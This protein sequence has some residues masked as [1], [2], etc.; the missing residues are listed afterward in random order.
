MTHSLFGSKLLA[1]LLGVS[2]S[3]A[4]LYA[5]NA[6]AAT[7]C[8]TIGPYDIL[9]HQ[10]ELYF[11]L[12]L[13][14]PLYEL[15]LEIII[16]LGYLLYIYMFPYDTFLEE[17]VTVG[18]STVEI[19]GSNQCLESIARDEAVVCAVDVGRLYEFHQTCLLG[20]AVKAATLHNLTAHR[21]EKPLLFLGEVVIQDIAY[22]SFDDCVAQVLQTLV[23]FLLFLW[24]IMIER[25]MYECL[26]IHGDV[27]GIESEYLVET[28]SK[29]FIFAA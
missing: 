10:L 3:R 11:V 2:E 17:T 26:T 21:G 5:L 6:Y 9:V 25:T 8:G 13:L 19:D 29:G 4:C 16:L 7:E 28:A 12:R 23:V 15:A 22:Y 1:L 20:Y 24:T 18:I 14:T 27:A